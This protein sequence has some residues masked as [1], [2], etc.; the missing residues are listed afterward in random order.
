[1]TGNPDSSP[2]S[3]SNQLKSAPRIYVDAED[4]LLDNS[5]AVRVLGVVC[6][7]LGCWMGY[8][9]VYKP[10]TLAL[11]NQQS[12]SIHSGTVGISFIGIICG[13]IML[14]AGRHARKILLDRWRNAT[15]LK[16]LITFSIVA[17]SIAFDHYFEQLLSGLGYVITRLP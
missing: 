1:M 3:R 7:T 17:A 4:E 12:F 8:D 5:T 6:L 13:V 9:N 11:A 15:P 10:L 14:I 2:N 16:V